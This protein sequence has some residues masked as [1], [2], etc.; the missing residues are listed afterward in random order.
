[1][2]SKQNVFQNMPMA[3]YY[4][5]CILVGITIVKNNDI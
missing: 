4:K 2:K 1:M 5:S 3:C